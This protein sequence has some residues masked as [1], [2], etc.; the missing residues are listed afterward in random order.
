M[1]F[2]DRQKQL[3]PKA[4]CFLCDAL[5]PYPTPRNRFCS[6]SWY[7]RQLVENS[8]SSDSKQV[9][10]SKVD[11]EGS[12]G[13]S[14]GQG[15]S[16]AEVGEMDACDR[17][18]ESGGRGVMSPSAQLRS[19]DV[20]VGIGFVEREISG[21]ASVMATLKVKCR[22]GHEVTDFIHVLVVFEKG[23]GKVLCCVRTSW[24]W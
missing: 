17:G 5:P 6:L 13:P 15:G 1:L 2:F 24:P 10:P 22:L 11:K 18:E 14:E 3:L 16:I 7:D 12:Y 23:R 8:R 21:E 20:E 4:V 9:K 19:E